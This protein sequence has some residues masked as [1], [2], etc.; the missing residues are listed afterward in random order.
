[1][2]DDAELRQALV[3]RLKDAGCITAAPV[4]AAFRAIPRHLFLPDL[5]PEQV[6]RDEA[7]PT[8]LR[9]GVAI[10]SS[11]QPAIMAIMLE[12]L[13]LRPGH[14]VLEIGAGTGYNAALMAHIVGDRGLIVT[15]DIDEDIVEGARAHLDAAGVTGVRVVCADGAAGFA[16]AAPYDRIIL[17]VGAEDIAPAWVEQLAPDGRLALPL[18]LGGPQVSVAFA[19]A[20]DGLES[21]S[22]VPCGFMPLRGSLAAH[23]ASVS[24]GSDGAITLEAG[25][26]ARVDAESLS[27]ALLAR[28]R[29]Q[30]T[31]LH[32]TGPELWGRFS[33]WLA[34]HEPGFCRLTSRGTGDQSPILPAL[35]RWQSVTTTFGLVDGASLAVLWRANDVESPARGTD[36]DPP[37]SLSPV[38]RAYGPDD[39][40]ASRLARAL[41]SW[42]A[43]GRPAVENLH[44]RAYPRDTIYSPRDGEIVVDKQATR[45]VLGWA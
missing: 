1:M 30:S 24:L 27:A 37:T 5:P 28:G 21:L 7:I 39:A 15:V 41:T 35:F 34:V 29:D 16:G 18:S 26:R 2:S 14:R 44:I 8:K 4:E 38:V 36:D 40:P 17:T 33:P 12:Q 10:S 3:E 43:A 20:G 45:F 22:V 6:Y 23:E 9:D 32:V 13:D 19:R 11:S 42:D 31:T 25:S